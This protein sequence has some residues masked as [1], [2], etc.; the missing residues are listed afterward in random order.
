MKRR[1]YRKRFTRVVYKARKKAP[2]SLNKS[3]S[4]ITKPFHYLPRKVMSSEILIHWSGCLLAQSVVMVFMPDQYARL[5]DTMEM[6]GEGLQE[7]FEN[8]TGGF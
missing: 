8:L 1:S 5:T 2:N 7:K 4:M 3:V 6:I